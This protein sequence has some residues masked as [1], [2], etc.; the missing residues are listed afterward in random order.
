MN[1]HYFHL[2]IMAKWMVH[3]LWQSGWFKIYGKVDGSRFM[4][5]W[6]VQKMGRE[7]KKPLP[8]PLPPPPPG[9]GA[10]GGGAFFLRPLFLNHPL[11][12]KS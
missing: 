1:N 3:D 8:L 11:F 7:A 5:E 6:M 10:G 9:G 4:K 12:H 2:W